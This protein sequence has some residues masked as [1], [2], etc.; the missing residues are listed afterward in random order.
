[1]I[2]HKPIGDPVLAFSKMIQNKS[3]FNPFVISLTLIMVVSLVVATLTIPTQMTEAFNWAKSAIFANFSWF[4]ILAFSIFLIFLMILSISSLGNIKLGMNEEEPE[5]PFLSW[6]AMLFAAG[7]GVGLM[8]FGVAEPLSHYFVTSGSPEYRQQ[9]AMLHTFFHWGIHAWAVY[10]VIALALAYFGFRYKL[11]LALRSCF[12]PL[13][14][15]KINGR[16]GDA[17]DVMALIATLFGII[18]T[19]G[20]G[21]SQLGA[22]LSQLGW[23]EESTFFIK[24]I[25]I[26]AVMSLAVFSAISGVGKGVKLLSEI[27]LGL[28][29]S[30]LLFVL[31]AGPTLYLLSAFS[32]NL[33]TYLTHLISLSFKTYAYETDKIGW[34]T[35]WTVLYWAWWCSWAPFVGL[36]I[37]RISRGRTIREFIF[38]VL[39]IP[40]LFCV[41]W[42]TVFGNSAIWL[43]TF[44]AN[45]TLNELTSSPEKLLFKFLDYLPIS[46]VT[47]LT[48]L[49]VISLF[50]ITSADSGIYVLNNIA[51]RDKSLS[52]PRWQAAMWGILMSIVAI[53]LMSVGGLATLQTMTL[54]VALPFAMLM[55]VMCLS[56]WKGLNAD[57]KYFETKTTPSSVFWTGDKWKDR[58]SQMLNQTQEKDI[59][60]FLKQ[61][62][63]PAMRE[64]RQELI[65]VHN[66]D[67]EII[68]S[69]DS[70]EP[71]VE[72]II[73]K[74]SMR[75][76][77]YGIKSV[78]HE[79]SEQLIEDQNM[80][81][82]Q[83]SMTYQPMTFFFDGRTGYDVQYMTRN[84]L[85]ADIL[86]QYERYLSLLDDVGQELMAH[87]QTEL[88]E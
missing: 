57:K 39:A 2:Y 61:T 82:I 70:E 42:F 79:V 86:R 14:K 64:L 47:S 5:F 4:Y 24:V 36:F 85:I 50:F 77:M 18:T 55:L 60:K 56:L 17:I 69:F 54:I 35:D 29:F 25:I 84:E 30:L 51:S 87:E 15:D 63:L 59:V 73:H 58:L 3:S 74:E 62:A 7:M 8:F 6:L 12:Y 76:F 48:A 33:G 53:V 41:L 71:S 23:I 88:A 19:L 83:H 45:G 72:F 1:M 26:I 11:P 44:V 34:F 31:I 27:N 22:G 49:V 32:D 52:S 20:F 10:A 9:E 81:H 16:I 13:L 40:S 43:D 21:A 65:G 38:G 78:G 80:P 66:L 68:Q 37:A 67:V 75:D 28:A 46:G